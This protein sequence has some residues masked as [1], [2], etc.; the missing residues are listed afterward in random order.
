MAE[1]TVTQDKRP[2]V[3]QTPLGKDK[4]IFRSMRVSEALGRPFEIDLE[5]LSTD[6]NLS[7]DKL[8]GE[9]VTVRMEPERGRK[10]RF[11]NGYVSEFS[12]LGSVGDHASYRATL[13]PW[14]WF[15]TRTSDCRIFQEKTV[16]QILEAVFQDHGFNDYELPD[17]SFRTWSYC[18]Q[19]RETDFNFV[20]RLLE[21]EGI[22]YHFEHE[23]GK[24]VLKL[25]T[26]D[27]SK[28]P[29]PDF[30]EIPYYTERRDP[31]GEGS[32][33]GWELTRHVQPT[34]YALDDYNYE[35][36]LTDLGADD[37]ITRS[38]AAGDYEVFDYPGEYTTPDEGKTYAKVRI[39]E[40]Q[41]EHERVAGVGDARG[42][43]CGYV[44]NLKGEIPRKDQLREYLVVAAEHMASGADIESGR[45]GSPV[46]YNCRFEAV[47]SKTPFRP[48]RTTAKPVVQGPQTAVVVGPKGEEVHTDEY[49][50]IKV[51]FHWDRYGKGDDNS[52]CWIRVAQSIAGNTWGGFTLPRIGQEVLVEFLEGDPDRPIVTGS[53]YNGANR[54]PFDLP[55]DKNCLGLKTNSTKEGGGGFNEISFDD[56]K[57][58]E[59][60]IVHGQK[61]MH[62][63][64]L[65]DRRETILNDRHL[66]VGKG[67]DDGVGN[68]FEYVNND[69]NVEIGNDRIEK[70]GHNVSLKVAGDVGEEISGNH[71]EVTS[72]DVYVKG[73]NIVLEAATNITLKVG[74]SSIA[75]DSSGITIETT[76]TI[77]GKAT[78]V[79][80]DANAQMELKSKGTA[81]LE[82]AGKVD[83][84]SGGM[85][86]VEGSGMAIIKGG[87]V[88]IN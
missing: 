20:S 38:H 1:A 80:V 12:Q 27:S 41:S 56:T 21:Q 69:V 61:D 47:D 25:C 79:K 76:G 59:Q 72:G 87:L 68:K 48:A 31:Y 71:S 2:I 26:P 70:I 57:D 88:K 32:I 7:F 62:I 39:E 36:P 50:R 55:S 22:Y 66:S 58:K 63:R 73:T 5:V 40:V 82:G 65:H 86:T 51:Q 29:F 49:G 54:P 53:L 16:P 81:K 83:V 64:V 60:L 13:R 24:H 30:K 14:L 43:A 84:K 18:V 19:Y 17:G 67:A 4:V 37:K 33:Y 34:K 42:I 74:G 11:F 78:K 23:N 85:T 45:S 3:V 28:E 15:L 8:L 9:N 6:F 52:S 75:I 35:K 10:A 77:E 46:E 44:F